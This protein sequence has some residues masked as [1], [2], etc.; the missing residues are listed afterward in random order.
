[1]RVTGSGK[2]G[3]VFRLFGPLALLGALVYA[4]AVRGDEL[5]APIRGGAANVPPLESVT[6]ERIEF[7]PSQIVAHVRNS[8][9]EDLTIAQIHLNDMTVEGFIAPGKTIQRLGTAT[10]TIPH[11]WV[12]ADPYEIRL[13]SADGLFHTGTVDAAAMT[14]TANSRY[15]I[16]FA[17]LGIYVGVIPLYL[18]LAWF[19]FLK[20]MGEKAMRFLTAFT[21]GLL[22]FLGIDAILE[23]FDAQGK[24]AEPFKPGILI[25]GGVIVSF[26]ALSAVGDWL[27][28]VGTAKGEAFV[29]LGIAYMIAVGIGLHNLGE[30]LA[31][32]AAY[33]L[34]AVGLGSTLIIGFTIHNTTEGIAVVAPITRTGASL[35]NLVFL[36]FIAGAP[37]IMGTW[38]GGLASSP[39]WSLI[40]LSIGAGAIFQVVYIIIKQMGANSLR[41]LSTKEGFVG[42]T[43]GL[44]VMY[45][46]SLLLAK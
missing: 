42:V 34:G 4:F 17:L 2:I 19:P 3:A 33:S 9:A 38:V 27:T 21:I 36:G 32:G 14:P 26:L 25:V 1:M 29:Q 28:K 37:T 43:T 40:F 45:A 22:V 44:A 23:A 5:T 16:V 12:E 30:G 31:I 7:K 20:R 6:F 24:V 13:V 41:Q 15:L 8:G 18:G 46:T 35:K 10:V 39:L 11:D